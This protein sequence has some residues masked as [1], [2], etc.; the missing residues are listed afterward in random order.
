MEAGGTKQVSGGGTGRGRSLGGKSNRN[1]WFSLG[2]LVAKK[3]DNKILSG[4]N[5]A[6]KESPLQEGEDLS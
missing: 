5:M 6:E 2:R 4:R 1:P 3:V